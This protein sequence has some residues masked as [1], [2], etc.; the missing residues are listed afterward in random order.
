[1]Q[2]AVQARTKTLS[3]VGPKPGSTP[4]LLITLVLILSSLVPS[5]ALL[6]SIPDTLRYPSPSPQNPSIYEGWMDLLS[7]ANSVVEI[8]AFYFTLRDS[9]LQMDDPSAKPVSFSLGSKKKKK[10][11]GVCVL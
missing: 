11:K 3:E 1:M 10:K 8:A 4:S 9:D 2:R 7:G 6:E 5:L